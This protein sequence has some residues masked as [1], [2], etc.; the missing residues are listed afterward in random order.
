M[1]MK[2]KKF[3][4]VMADARWRVCPPVTAVVCWFVA[5]ACLQLGCMD[6]FDRTPPPV[7]VVNHPPHPN[8]D[9]FDTIYGTIDGKTSASLIIDSGFVTATSCTLY[10]YSKY[11]NGL[12]PIRL[13]VDS[14][15]FTANDKLTRLPFCPD[16]NQIGNWF[17][18]IYPNLIPKTKYYLSIKG[19]W[20][21]AD[22]W[23]LKYSFTTRADSSADT[24]NPIP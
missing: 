13:G 16:T 21:I 2:Q 12:L 19:F 14:T 6:T 24:S 17:V 3:E 11:C 22:A 1:T 4:D 20:S 15:I 8:S 18:Y 5:C 7:V 10:I 9:R 23:V